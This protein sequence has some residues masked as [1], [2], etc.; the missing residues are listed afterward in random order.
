MGLMD[1][2]EQEIMISIP[3]GPKVFKKNRNGD[4]RHIRIYVRRWLRD[5]VG[6]H[7]LPLDN[8]SDAYP[9]RCRTS[10]INTSHVFFFRHRHHALLFKLMFGGC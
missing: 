4:L 5:N 2:G 3:Y 10:Q 8:C 9:W 1:N 6:P 7:A